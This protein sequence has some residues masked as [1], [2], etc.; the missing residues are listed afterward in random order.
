MQWAVS[1]VAGGLANIHTDS[2]NAPHASN[3]CALRGP[4]YLSIGDKCQVH[5]AETYWKPWKHQV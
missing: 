3:V 1:T 4:S 2:S 5:D